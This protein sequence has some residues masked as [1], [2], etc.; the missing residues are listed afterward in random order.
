MAQSAA[1]DILE[2]RAYLLQQLWTAGAYAL[3]VQKEI[4]SRPAKDYDSPFAQAVTDADIAVQ[5][6][7]EVSLLAR[8]PQLRFFGEEVDQSLSMK[9]FSTD[10]PWEV[11][12][13]PIDGTRF[14]ADGRRD[15]NV[16]VSVVDSRSYQAGIIYMPGFEKCVHAVQGEP[17]YLAAPNEIARGEI[18]QVY[19]FPSA[20]RRIYCYRCPEAVTALSPHFEVIDVAEAYERDPN[21]SNI[22]AIF[23]GEACAFLGKGNSAIDWGVHAFLV[24]RAGGKASTWTGASLPEVQTLQDRSFPEML[25]ATSDELHSEIS[26]LLQSG[27]MA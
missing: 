24:E 26:E 13:D 4:R 18:G 2:L 15:F 21:C 6:F 19:A 1:I 7:L 23:T 9:Y 10:H 14:Y 5:N 8:F 16:V 22:N 27:V 12:V 25:V 20:P 11:L 3:E 17:T